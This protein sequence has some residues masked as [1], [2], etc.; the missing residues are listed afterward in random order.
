LRSR[1]ALALALLYRR[2][3]RGAVG[4]VLVLAALALWSGR[5]RA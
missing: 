1:G 4:S 2:N 5:C 3:R